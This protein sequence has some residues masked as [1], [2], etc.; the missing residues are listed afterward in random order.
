MYIIESEENIE[1]LKNKVHSLLAQK[2]NTGS[3][4]FCRGLHYQKLA[5][6]ATKS[7]PCMVP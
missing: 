7:L 2:K 4:C 1:S 6:N 5:H 3:S